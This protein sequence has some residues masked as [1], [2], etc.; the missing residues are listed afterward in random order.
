MLMGSAVVLKDGDCLGEF[1]TQ[2]TLT[3]LRR[4]KFGDSICTL[5]APEQQIENEDYQ[6][7]GWIQQ[8]Q[9]VNDTVERCEVVWLITDEEENQYF[10]QVVEANKK[11]VPTQSTKTSV[12]DTVLSKLSTI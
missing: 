6:G 8:L 11:A 3:L 7:T 5:A 10:S 9:L 4:L 1:A 12:V 2:R